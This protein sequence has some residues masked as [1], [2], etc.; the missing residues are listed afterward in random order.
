MGCCVATMWQ[1]STLGLRS[2]SQNE[3]HASIVRPKYLGMVALPVHCR[4]TASFRSA[5]AVSLRTYL[6]WTCYPDGGSRPGIKASH[7]ISKSPDS[8]IESVRR[9]LTSYQIAARVCIDERVA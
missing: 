9:L 7:C 4:A 3:F 6:K 1:L 5:L 8:R 2:S